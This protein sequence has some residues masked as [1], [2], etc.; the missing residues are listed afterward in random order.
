MEI[1]EHAIA[2]VALTIMEIVLGIDNIIFIAILTSR[3]PKEQQPAARG[4]GLGLA[5]IMRLLLLLMLTWIMRADDAIFTFSELFARFGWSFE[6]AVNRF[7][8]HEETYAHI[9][10]VS[11]RDLIML[12]GGLFLIWKSVHEI[13]KKLEGEHDGQK[14]PRPPSFAGVLVQIALLD[15]V[16]SLDSVIT[17]V[18]MAREI[19]VMITAVILA[20]G[21]MLVFAGRISAFVE[22]HPTLKMLA[23]CF[24]L[25]I[26]VMLVADGI[27]TE[28]SKGYIYF[29]MAFA[30]LVE[31]LNLWMKTKHPA[32]PTKM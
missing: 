10:E 27:G 11:I 3:L 28:I 19:W 1:A 8:L 30:V 4:L 6:E 22:R 20:V 18:G 17:A 23:L 29:A 15:I 31:M 25:L 32:Q 9:N 7:R 5:L 13:H 14:V 26:G 21:V 2:L 24:L 12:G 16:F